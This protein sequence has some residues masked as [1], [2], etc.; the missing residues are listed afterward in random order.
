[1]ISL[2]KKII[3]LTV[4]IFF[5]IAVNAQYNFNCIIQNAVTK[6]PLH[7]ASVS[8]DGVNKSI[9][10]KDG[11]VLI[12]DLAK[13]EYE[14]IITNTGYAEK[15]LTI[16]IPQTDTVLII[17]LQPKEEQ[18]DEVIVSSFRNNS[19]IEDLPTKVEVLGSE[20]VGEENGIKP[21]N[22]ASL[23][24]DIAGIQIQQTSA[25]TGNADARVQGLPGKYTQILR[26]GLPLFGGYSG[27]FS[28]LQIPPADLKQIE[29]VKGASS[30]LY[31]GGAI[32]G[33]INL[34]SKTPKQNKL[35][36]EITIN[37]STLKESNI[38]AYFSNRTKS[39]GY[40]FFTGG[41]YQKQV[42]VNK[43]GFSDVPNLKTVFVHPRFFFYPN[44]KQ[45][46]ILG[47]NLTYEERK[48]GDMLVLNDKVDNTHQFFNQSKS[49]RNTADVEF[50]TK[51][52]A[53]DKLT[54]KAVTSFFNRDISTN[55]FGMKANQLSWYT[56]L[57][58][59]K[60]LKGH[61]IVGGLNFTG[62]NFTKKK[63]DSTLIPGYRQKTFG[64][65]IQDD[66]KLPGKFTV[67]TGLRFDHHNDY[68]DFVLPRVSLLY[69]ISDHFTTRFGGGL[70]YKTPSYFASEIDEREY[71]KILLNSN[72]TA[73]KSKGIN[74]DINYHQ[75][76]NQWHLTVNQLF[77]ITEITKPVVINEMPDN[78]IQFI[79]AAKPL[80]T[81]GFETYIAATHNELELY[82]GYTYTLAKQLYNTANPFVSLSARSKFA[83]IIAY[84]FSEK[85][86]AG[87]EAAYTGRQY[88][89]DKS[90]TPSY[91]FAA[92]MMRYNFKNV[93]LVLNCENLFDYRQT[94][95][96]AIYTGSITN[97]VFK[98]IWA[99]LDG[100]V[101][102][103]SAKISL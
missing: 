23:L 103:L 49:V 45:T 36:K 51:F 9:S 44:D 79:N 98:Q 29:I 94:K 33:M 99:P 100:R 68:G 102:N 54:L 93:A 34:V 66:W 81:K 38:N 7:G 17:F 62:E 50:N 90:K 18:L 22:I 74:W 40:T 60:K 92:A 37:Q 87:I 31:G 16:V 56:E 73:E 13:G 67:Q 15:K 70:G 27:S 21:G 59:F 71:P 28:I 46:L 64:A 48:G 41:T 57:S 55:V 20:E 58:Y 3:V 30:T 83:S 4:L 82:F 69:K 97:P 26:D 52:D 2:C 43:D 96:E 12:H 95:K 86:R 32:A 63:P 101:I 77:Y 14:L 47:Y 8:L 88:L 10:Q 42:D 76:I 6:E 1:M 65:F 84:E 61:S 72:L 89:D 35:D 24:G 39:F 75:N 91:L 53:A 19:R 25:A 85:F 11:S 78:T 5:S 80:N